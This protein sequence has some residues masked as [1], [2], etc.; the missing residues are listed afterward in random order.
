MTKIYLIR[1]A[2][3]EGNLYGVMQ[4]HWNGRVTV[5][6]RKEI[7]ALAERMKDEKLDALV[8]SD[9]YRAMETAKAITKYHPLAL[10]TDPRLRELNLGTWEAQSFRTKE[11]DEPE[12]MYCYRFAPDRWK[13]PGSET[14]EEAGNR[15]CA[16]LE[17]IGRRY[18]GQTVAVVSHG[19]TIRCLAAKLMGLPV[20]ETNS[21]PVCANTGISTI[22]YRDGRLTLLEYNN[23]AHLDT[24]ETAAWR[25]P[26][27]WTREIRFESFDPSSDRKFYTDC[28]ASAWMSAHGSLRGFSPVPYLRTAVEHYACDPGAVLRI[29]DR[30]KPVGLIDMD[31]RRGAEEGCGW[32]SLVYLAPEYRGCGCGI[33][34]LGQAMVYFE[35]AGRRALRLHCASA[36]TA[37]L[38]FYEKWGFEILSGEENGLGTL[39]LLEKSFEKDI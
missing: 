10:Q 31:P 13:T 16:A 8:S 26:L 6:G 15:A 30:E 5:L 2:Q 28:Y 37:A 34:A 4:G 11:H 18:E 12:R 7:G 20:S 32:L 24:P 35:L 17:D 25:L 33:Q 19:I 38:R 29:F 22:E 23:A 39:Y 9:L 14:F 21:I 36:N 27:P 3:A 1:H